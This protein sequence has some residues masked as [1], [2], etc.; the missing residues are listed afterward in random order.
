MDRRK[1][2]SSLRIQRRQWDQPRFSQLNTLLSLPLPCNGSKEPAAASKWVNITGASQ[3]TYTTPNTT[4]RMNGYQYRVIISNGFGSPVISDAAVLTVM[5]GTFETAD[6]SIEKLDGVYDPVTSNIIWTIRVHNPGTA[7]AVGITVS[8]SL[9]AGTRLV[10]I[11]LNSI[12]GASSKA[13]G[14]NVT[15]D[16]G[17]MAPGTSVTFTITV[18]VL[19]ASSPV[20]NTVV[21]TLSSKL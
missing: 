16:I 2:L 6:I 21:L 15:V 20:Y 9:Q 13:R 1:S 12:P 10:S 3:A 17:Q 18:N 7:E 14:R 19:R 5:P 11:D 8:D 4:T